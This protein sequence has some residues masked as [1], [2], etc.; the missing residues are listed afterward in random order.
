M[1]L[2]LNGFPA[3]SVDLDVDQGATSENVTGTAV[4]PV[5]V[6]GEAKVLRKTDKTWKGLSVTVGAPDNG[7][8]TDTLEP[9]I[10]FQHGLVTHVDGNNMGVH[11]EAGGTGGLDDQEY[12]V[13]YFTN[14]QVDIYRITN[15]EEALV[16]SSLTTGGNLGLWK[17]EEGRS[18]AY[19]G[20][21]Y[22]FWLGGSFITGRQIWL[23]IAA[24]GEDYLVGGIGYTSVTPQNLNGT[25]PT[26]TNTVQIA[27][28]WTQPEV[29]SGSLAAPATVTASFDA[30]GHRRINV[31]HSLVDG[32]IGYVPFITYTDPATHGEWRYLT[33]ADDGGAA[34]QT[35][36][37]WV[38][39]RR[40]TSPSPSM[41][42]PRAGN[43]LS[44]YDNVYGRGMR[45]QIFD[46][47]TTGV[48]AAF[49]TFTE[50]EPS[51][52]LDKVGDRYLRVSVAGSA[53]TGQI[54]VTQDRWCSDYAAQNGHTPIV[55]ETYRARFLGRASRSIQ[56][57]LVHGAVD[58]TQY[59]HTLTTSWAEYTTDVTVSAPRADGLGYVELYIDFDGAGAVDVD[60]AGLV[61]YRTS[62]I[63]G[64]FSTQMKSRLLPGMMVRDHGLIKIS[65]T[66]YFLSD[67]IAPY[68][69]MYKG[70]TL[71]GFLTACADAGV[72]PW[73]QVEW[74]L[75]PT[76]WTQLMDYLAAPVSSG[77]AMATI[78][79]SHGR[80]EPWVDAF[81][82]ILFEFGNEAWNAR[83][84][85]VNPENGRLDV[86]TSKIYNSGENFG[87]ICRLAALSM[88]ASQWNSNKVKWV[89]GG[90]SSLTN[91]AEFGTNAATW[92]RLPV[93]IGIAN[94][95]GGWDEN[96]DLVT[97]TDTGYQNVMASAAT[98]AFP[99]QD[100]QVELLQAVGTA[101]SEYT[102]NA[103]LFPTCY[104]AGPGYQLDGLNGA[105][106]TK[107]EEISQ[108][109]IMASRAA[110]T[111]AMD[112]T[113]GQAVRGFRR[114][115]FFTLGEDNRLWTAY[116]RHADGDETYPTYEYQR[117]LASR[118]GTDPYPIDSV[119]M[120]DSGA[121]A[122]DNDGVATDVDAIMLYAF[123][124]ATPFDRVVV[125]VGNRDQSRT[126]KPTICTPWTTATTCTAWLNTGPYEEHNRWA[127][128]FRPDTN[129]DLT[130]ADSNCVSFD[131][132]STAIT[133]PSD[134]GRIVCD[135]SFGFTSSGILPGNFGIFEFNGVPDPDAQISA[136][137]SFTAAVG[138]TAVT[139]TAQV[140]GV[141]V[142]S[143]PQS[144][145]API[146]PATVSTTGKTLAVSTATETWPQLAWDDV[147][148]TGSLT[149]YTGPTDI[150]S[151]TTLENYRF[152]STIVQLT[153]CASLTI[154]NCHF[155]IGNAKYC[156]DNQYNQGPN[157]TVLIEDCTFEG[158]NSALL[159]VG[160]SGSATIRRSRFR[161]GLRDLIKFQGSGTRLM[162]A[163]YFGGLSRTEF[164]VNGVLEDFHSDGFQHN[165]SGNNTIRGCT[166]DF[167]PTSGGLQIP[168][169]PGSWLESTGIA[170]GGVSGQIYYRSAIAYFT[171]QNAS[172]TNTFEYN[173]L[174]KMGSNGFQMKDDVNASCTYR[175]LGNKFYPAGIYDIAR[176]GANGVWVDLGGNEWAVSGTDLR[177]NVRT[178][179]QAI[180]F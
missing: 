50:G 52:Y 9:R 153:S 120:R 175:F 56:T 67:L 144:F 23:G 168:V 79:A 72:N 154:R 20:T 148:H 96:G 60:L 124:C 15:G 5:P 136:T 164:V 142:G 157:T 147:G 99:R 113:L 11:I 38:L 160:G 32:A 108:A 166:F 83:T 103:N 150:T 109:A 112:T 167:P 97:E 161:D 127:A 82:E 94:Y 61:V 131:Y 130:I 30:S 135:D 106:L 152:T 62:S 14:A 53:A 51:G 155:D 7:W 134:M 18:V 58:D 98:R 35:G 170:V 169:T 46:G 133:V 128:G 77:A 141:D 16:R 12:T 158:T 104:E 45:R 88:R 132:S 65:N 34:I 110:A 68:G 176:G 162:E 85:F 84:E 33:L 111:A 37:R 1:D 75:S 118:L 90:R 80:T 149:T 43:A 54:Q 140:L 86:S 89:L 171:F 74:I 44:I 36:D 138:A 40:I 100:Y 143:S 71:H 151:S 139:T 59:Q 119:T 8:G 117:I 29:I 95:N 177:G 22:S 6:T 55:G 19:D 159:I 49:Q 64:G 126:I 28:N 3:G 122:A 125:I 63:A 115:N 87:L 24:I 174:V 78:R 123:R 91:T 17:N 156:F 92:F 2:F 76:E 39:R 70:T 101:V 42:G 116:Q 105:A 93:E 165:D 47:S 172:S 137:V 179:G 41:L 73:L 27:Q 107:T 145:T 10:N 180:T 25:Q 173:H 69:A 129:G 26:N 13:E 31:T 21:G 102:Y 146:V 48:T 81:D 4:A 163:C 114:A 66:G 57:S 178:A 121:T